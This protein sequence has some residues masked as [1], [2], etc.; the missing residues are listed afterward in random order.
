MKNRSTITN[1]LVLVSQVQKLLL[2][3]LD[4]MGFPKSLLNWISSCLEDNTQKVVFNDF[5]SMNVIVSSG[6]PLFF[7]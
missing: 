4:L 7:I 1:L 6:I 2:H 5:S 3:K